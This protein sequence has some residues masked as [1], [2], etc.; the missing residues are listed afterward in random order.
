MVAH[1][2]SDELRDPHGRWTKGGSALRRMV[3]E[4][5]STRTGPS[6][7][8]ITGHIRNIQKGSGRTIGGHH[9]DRTQKDK[10][11]VG[12]KKEGGGRDTRLYDSPED[13]A[14]AMHEGKH[15]EAGGAAAVA[16]GARDRGSQKPAAKPAAAGAQAGRYTIVLT[17]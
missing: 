7:E 12:L 17:G 10:Y 2:V 14:R 13:A 4:A 6:H 1:D 16:G 15:H 11:R 3:R 9:I 5:A 8:E